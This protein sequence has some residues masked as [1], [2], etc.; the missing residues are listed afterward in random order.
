VQIDQI[1]NL[2]DILQA[3]N[4]KANCV[5]YQCIDNYFYYDIQLLSKTKVN[6]IKRYSDVISLALK[7][8]GA[9]NFKI[10]PKLGI[11]RLEFT[12]LRS[13]KLKLFEYFTNEDVPD[14]DLICLLGQSS[15]GERMWVDLA[16]NPHMIIAGSTGSGKS[17]LLHNI[18]ANIIN[19]NN[20]NLLLIDPKN[21][22][23]ENYNKLV[24]ANIKVYHSYSESMKVID[25]MINLMEYNYQIMRNGTPAKDIL[26][27]VLI[28]D[29]FA[30][31][32]MQ[33]KEYQFHDK[34]CKLAQKCRSARISIILSTQ[35]PS[36]SV[37]SGAIKA[38]F[39][40]RIACRVA[41]HIDSKVILDAVGAENLLGHGDA[42][43]RGSHREIERFQVAYTDSTEICNKFQNYASS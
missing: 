20:A 35:R 22:E 16:Q 23:F 25:Y 40:A 18:I 2:N 3:L 17:T 19:F 14:G 26:Y 13:K 34:L 5:N 28:I 8:E 39:P 12:S 32:I 7:T 41:S 15:Y 21:I 6:A 27:T 30:D 31:L 4:I 1:K 42:L 33:D 10:I 38:N 9:P 29:E 36:V 43:L 11:I 37:V 24:G